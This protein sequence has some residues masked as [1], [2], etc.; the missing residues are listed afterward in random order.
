MSP[1]QPKCAIPACVLSTADQ[2]DIAELVVAAY[3]TTIETEITARRR[4]LEARLHA[5]RETGSLAALRA[6]QSEHERIRKQFDPVRGPS[7][8]QS[9]PSA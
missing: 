5:F 2:I 1:S 6:A 7:K 3:F 9:L 8:V 4:S